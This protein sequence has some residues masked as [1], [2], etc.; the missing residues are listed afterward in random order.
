MITSRL[1]IIGKDFDIP[2]E[3]KHRAK[4][5]QTEGRLNEATR[6]QVRRD[7]LPAGTKC[8]INALYTHIMAKSQE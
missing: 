8:I 1:Y 3:L 4:M 2:V 5:Q 7:R 6:N